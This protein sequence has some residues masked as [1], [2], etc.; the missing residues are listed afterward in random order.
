M[1]VELGHHM[2]VAGFRRNK[3]RIRPAILPALVGS[4][5]VFDAESARAQGDTQPPTVIAQS[6]ASGVNWQSVNVNVTATFSEAIQPNSVA[7]SL[8]DS[9]SNV[10]P[11][12]LSY[13]ST[14]HIMTLD[15][16]VELIPREPTRR[17]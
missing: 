17:R 1:Q 14:S 6:P 11:A 2:H 13:D 8:T 10:I 7:F 12:S 5:F 9:Q 4:I 16:S 15:P 3:S